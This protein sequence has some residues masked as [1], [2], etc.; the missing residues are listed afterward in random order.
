MR[1]SEPHAE[2]P[3]LQARD[4]IDFTP[5]AAGFRYIRADRHLLTT[6]F[7]KM[8]GGILGANLVLLPVI[9]QRVFPIHGAGLEGGRGAIL[10][11]SLLFGARG[12]GTLV[13]PLVA[14]R[15]AGA[16]LGRLRAG[17]AVGFVFAAAGYLL[18]G[19]AG[20]L[21]LAAIAVAIA[22]GAS[23]INWVFSTTLL[24]IYTEDRFRG[25]VLAA[26]FGLC[27]LTISAAGYL[28]GV[29]LDLGVNPRT[30][31]TAVGCVMLVPAAAWVVSLLHDQ[32]AKL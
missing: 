10:A 28:A 12:A 7:V 31:A 9:G 22:H 21:V 27:M 30:L 5:I 1:F 16:R 26:E 13:G 18:L 6:V 19:R 11:T 2:G 3:P 23:S 14:A 32:N 15:W 25:R 17:I 4:L 24:Q 8:G 29:A 20:A